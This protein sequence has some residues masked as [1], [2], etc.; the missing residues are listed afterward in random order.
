MGL[1]TTTF[2]IK[3]DSTFERNIAMAG[4]VYSR[5]IGKWSVSNQ[6]MSLVMSNCQATLETGALETI[7]CNPKSEEIPIQ[8]SGKEWTIPDEAGNLVFKKK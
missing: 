6:K 2:K 5:E 1:T 8:I 7:E 3:A 4:A